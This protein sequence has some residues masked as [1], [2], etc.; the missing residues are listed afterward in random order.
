MSRTTSAMSF[1]VYKVYISTARRVSP[2]RNGC[3]WKDKDRPINVPSGVSK[4]FVAE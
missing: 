1:E 4:L 3:R 2:C